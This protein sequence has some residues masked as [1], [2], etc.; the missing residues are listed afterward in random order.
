[1]LGEVLYLENPASEDM[2]VGDPCRG[3]RKDLS[4]RQEKAHRCVGG[5]LWIPEVRYEMICEYV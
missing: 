1:L 3:K 4:V 2:A 5:M